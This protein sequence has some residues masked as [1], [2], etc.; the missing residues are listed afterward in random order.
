M[1]RS[2]Q[3]VLWLAG[4]RLG[5]RSGA[6]L[7]VVLG[8]AAGAALL[9]GVQVATTVAQDRALAQAIERIPEG[10]GS[11]RTAW[12]GVPGT[13]GDP[14]PALDASVRQALAGVDLPRGTA[15]VLLRET[16]IA[17]EFASLGGI[18]GLGRWVR[19]RSGRLP[20]EC[21]PERCEVLRLRGAG[22]L[23]QPEGL[24]LVEVGEATLPSR[25]L[26]GD[27]LAPTD[28]ALTN[29]EV[30]PA[31]AAA[32][33]YHRP[34]PPPL[35]LAEGVRTLAASPALARVYRSYAWVSPL[36]EGQPRLWEVDRLAADVTRAR[37]ELQ[38]ETIS[39]DLIA[40]LDELR[41]AQDASRRAGH[42]LALVGGQAAVLVFAFAIL[43]AATL[44]GDLHAARRRL[45]WH[46]GRSWQA[47]L[48]TGVETLGLATAGMLLG[49]A[50]GAAV[51]ALVAR[52]A[53]TPPL[54]VLAESVV[55]ARTLALGLAI[56]AGVAGVLA[57]AA[58]LTSPGLG[59]RRFSA[60]DGAAAVALLVVAAAA[61]RGGDGDLT[62]LLPGL[63][64]FGAA[65]LV[66]RVL[67]PALRLLER[68]TRRSSVALRLAV[69]SLARNPGY[70]VLT[71]AFLVVSF[72]LALFAES[73][74]A[75]LSQGERDQA[76]FAV[77]RDFLL[78]EDLTRLIPVLD[79]ASVERFRAV[80][81][82]EVD[83][84]LRLTGGVSRLEGESGVTVLGLP[85]ASLPKL[86]GW[87][88]DF[89]D[90][91]ADLASQIERNDVLRGTMLPAGLDELVA[92]ADGGANV[93]VVAQLQ[94]PRGRFRR[95]ELERSGDV[96]R[97]PVPPE[98]RGGRLVALDLEPVTRLQ[99]RGA[100]AGQAVEGSVRLSFESLPG[101]LDG[102]AGFGGATLN[103][104]R[105]AYTLT[106]VEAARVRPR[107]LSDTEPVPVLATPR[108]ARAAGADGLLPLQVGG[109]RIP[110][111]VAATVERFPGIDGPGIV[112]DV[113]ALGAALNSERPGSARV[114][115]I[116]LGLREDEDADRVAATL[117]QAP[118]DVLD[119]E[120]RRSLEAEAR[121]DPIAHGTLL[122]LLVAAFV[123]L[124]L[125]LAGLV[126]TVLGDLRDE[127][128]T[129][130][131]LEA[132]GVGPATLRRIV[133][134]R[135]LLVAVAGLAAGAVTGL[136]L[137]A[138]VT[139][140]V[141]LTARASEAEPPLRLDLD[142]LVVSGALAVYA[143]L[144]VGLVL[145]ATA[146]SFAADRVP[147]RVE[148]AE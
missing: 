43:A 148:G 147:R 44:R 98:A 129:L 37:S 122:T 33:G 89:G 80:D 133:R 118:F 32:A 68:A 116:W 103:G 139:D 18:E 4:R 141:S 72:G 47:A 143:V 128:G 144:A 65:V 42:R 15:V 6:R 52:R 131:D 7:L 127:R 48:L 124:V 105:I 120:S 55:D 16:T 26:M 38:A 82:V 85:P 64:T 8:I 113:D 69:L 96:L 112:G 78:R 145:V 45:A 34:A 11:V 119:V 63:A 73:Y 53:G 21:R 35:F 29:A 19:V 135:A 83:P 17:G 125:A 57:A 84:V 104:G 60:L 13:N 95:L 58:T 99:E 61:Y 22:R 102:W 31:F 114:G 94:T 1:L 2:A 75:T 132:Q 140:L 87:R 115:E 5:R 79:A 41:D 50:A 97:A 9:V 71:T 109:T 110:V 77:P 91:P 81:G 20:R 66:A 107:Q 46:G 40:P 101:A 3:Y 100:D 67:R 14:Q 56:L 27:F 106:N 24:R 142:P 111:R 121:R 59:Q 49:C 126:L 28:N 93:A 70:A 123:A 88:D 117:A 76:A 10:S 108:L 86:D 51:G 134:L 137:G 30:S 138:L 136:C 74:R 25:E 146:R 54:A 36:R 92:S 12:F 90:P 23:P 39:F 62:L 130:F